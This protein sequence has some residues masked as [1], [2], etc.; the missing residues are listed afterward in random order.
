[1]RTSPQE[2]HSGAVEALLD[3]L[4]DA[5]LTASRVA[6]A[7]VAV[8]GPTGVILVDVD[9][10]SVI[11]EDRARARLATGRAATR[12]RMCVIV[13]DQIS[14]SARELLRR[15][16]RGYLDRRGAL[17]LRA[18]GLVVSDTSLAPLGRRRPRRDDPIRGR[19]GLGV[20]LRRLMHPELDESVR[21]IAAVLGAAPSTVHDAL[22]RLREAALV[23]RTGR[24]LVPDLF[25]AAAAV[26]RPERIPVRRLPRPDDSDL[27]VSPHADAG[28][29]HVP[30]WVVGGDL[31]AAAAGAPVIVSSDAPPDFYVPTDAELR[32]AVRRL[33]ECDLD[34]R[35]ASVA[36]AP[37]RIV[38]LERVEPP[39]FATP[40]LHWPIAHPVVLALDLAQD[41]A[42]GREI[43]DQWTPEGF[44]RVW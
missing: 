29:S 23:D 31:G 24:P 43:L 6:D 40:W 13:A 26:W 33:G 37:S 4:R 2:L 36:L 25:D 9:A 1:M 22:A 27:D 12:G 11:D 35:E 21:D 14:E 16:D 18:P 30:G 3:A 28:G 39:S 10:A 42:R 5:G 19:V 20:A 15:S 8:R 32:R 17:W 41:L 7:D 34:E 38:T 44:R